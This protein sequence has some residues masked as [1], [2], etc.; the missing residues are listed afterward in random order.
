MKTKVT[1]LLSIAL[2][3]SLFMQSAVFAN[4]SISENSIP[5]STGEN[6]VQIDE[7]DVSDQDTGLPES[8]S[9]CESMDFLDSGIDIFTFD[10]SN[11]TDEELSHAILVSDDYDTKAWIASLPEEDKQ[12]LLSRDT[13]LTHTYL[14]DDIL[15]ETFYDYLQ[16]LD[17]RLRSDKYKATSAGMPVRFY[18]N[19]A[20]SATSTIRYTFSGVTANSSTLAS[21]KSYKVSIDNPQYGLYVNTTKT[22]QTLRQQTGSGDYDAIS[23]V[24]YFS[25]PAGFGRA[26]ANCWDNKGTNTGWFGITAD[27]G[28]N[29]IK[30]NSNNEITSKGTAYETVPEAVG[31]TGIGR[32]VGY[33]IRYLGSGFVANGYSTTN[34]GI[35]INYYGTAYTVY[36]RN[37]AGANLSAQTVYYPSRGT[38]PAS[39]PAYSYSVAYN[40]NGGNSA[41]SA[42]VTRTHNGW[43]NANYTVPTNGGSVVVTATYADPGT[44]IPGAT[45]RAGYTHAG[46]WTAASGGTKVTGT[47]KPGTNATLYAHWTANT[48]TITYSGNGGTPSQAS[49][50]VQ[51]AT[52]PTIN[53]TATRTGYTFKGWTW[54]GYTGGGAYA[55]AGNSTATAKWEANNYTL[56]YD[57]GENAT[58][59]P[60]SNAVTY[61]LPCPTAPVPE[62]KGYTFVEWEGGTSSGVYKTAGNTTVHAK[63]TPITYKVTYD[64]NGSD[65]V[66]DDTD[67][68]YDTAFTFPQP[69][70]KENYNFAGWKDAK[71]NLY[72]AGEE[73]QNLTDVQDD[74]INMTAQWVSN[75]VTVKFDAN[76]GNSLADV[77]YHLN[78]NTALPVATKNAVTNDGVKNGKAG[79]ITTTYTFIGWYDDADYTSDI[80]ANVQDILKNASKINNNALTLYAKFDENESF[81][82][83]VPKA[84]TDNG[85]KITQVETKETKI[86]VVDNSSKMD[87]I[88]EMLTKFSSLSQLSDKQVSDVSDLL[89][90]IYPLSSSQISDLIKLIQNSSLNE[91]AKLTLIKALVQGSL[92]DAQKEMLFTIIKTSS[93]SQADKESLYNAFSGVLQLSLSEQRKVLEA[94]TKGSSA[95][96]TISGIQYEVKKADNGG[97]QVTIKQMS[98][99]SVTIPDHITIAG[100]TYPITKIADN[101]FKGNKEVKDVKMGD[102]VTAIGTSAFEGCSGLKSISL[103]SGIVT[104]GDNAFK[105][106]KALPS[107]TIPAAT[108]SIGN[109]AFEGCVALKTI[110][111]K[112]TSKLL[113][114]GKKAFYNTGLSKFKLPKSVLRIGDSA[115][116]ANKNLNTYTFQ[117]SSSLTKLGKNVWENDSKLKSIKFPKGL[118]TLPAKSLKG[119]KTLTKVTLPSTLTDIGTSALEGCVKIKNI[120]IPGK[121]INI[122]KKAFYGDKKLKKIVV[123]TTVLKK[124]GSK[125]F[126]KCNKK[127]TFKCPKKYIAK[128]KKTFKGKY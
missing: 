53:A 58:V 99:D 69:G 90:K 124:C 92:T 94:L 105:N 68:T 14:T 89:S 122:G 38:A 22:Y 86:V 81:V 23:H 126:K 120:T 100:N 8:N 97:F 42:N 77:T 78:E 61:D 75:I 73:I 125:A 33:N 112:E 12:D 67:A 25:R 29:E 101:A 17:N 87:E 127:I 121:V 10:W 11:A 91:E 63:Y 59:S 30:V 76:G 123:K 57:P 54:N 6:N 108:Q 119:C 16:S 49:Q 84:E 45:T 19:G 102:N 106:C 104:I 98:G 115:F 114:I 35:E 24:F 28:N 55:Y 64:T 20:L 118:T 65:T 18:T 66:I 117:G 51:Y 116:A 88:L 2:S 79:K 34:V 70:T 103:S 107:I 95:N 71:G 5:D 72:Q 110:T 13:M 46:W 37:Y 80:Y 93:M 32:K 44:V 111:I 60:T 36:Y 56:T 47:Y 3:A 48:Y 43:S 62:K 1:K 9:E 27:G 74:V 50:N 26:N 39:V 96:I 4:P 31:S 41:A 109:S 128:Y 7:I 113:E 40:G 21:S 83:I 15:Y 52:T 82:A 85:D